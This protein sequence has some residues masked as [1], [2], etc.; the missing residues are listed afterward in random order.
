M[1]FKTTK[2]KGGKVKVT[3]TATGKERTMGSMEKAENWTRMAEAVKHGF[4][5]TGAKGTGRIVKAATKAARK[6]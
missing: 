1:P 2:L 4:K 3:N 6:K 5:P